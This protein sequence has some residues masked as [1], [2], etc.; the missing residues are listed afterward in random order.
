MM[1]KHN[2][3]LTVI[4]ASLIFTSGIAIADGGNTKK[5]ITTNSVSSLISG[6]LI[7]GT[8]TIV[9]HKNKVS[10][11]FNTRGLT[12]NNAYTLWIMHYDKPQKCLD[13][14]ACNL[15]D[16]GNSEVT[17]G[18]IGAMAGRVADAY[19]QLAVTNVV[20]YGVLPT[21]FAQVLVPNA[22]KNKK[23]HF[24]LILRDHGPASSD[25]SVLEEQLSSWTGACDINTCQDVVISDHPSPFC[26]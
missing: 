4:T 10:F 25:P 23:S 16:F 13:P 18:A 21:G 14:C 12:P 15:S 11:D 3:L 6:E 1:I 5:R 22:I 7:D 24:T 17:G 19:G 20:D 2:S 26:N 9:R 8:S